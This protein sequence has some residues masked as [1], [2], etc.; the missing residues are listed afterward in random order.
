MYPNQ[1][2]FA[3]FNLKTI[4]GVLCTPLVAARRQ[5]TREQAGPS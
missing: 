1:N 3:R 2:F 4:G 5:L